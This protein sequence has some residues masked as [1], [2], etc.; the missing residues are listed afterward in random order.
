MRGRKPKSYQEYVELGNSRG[1]T[2]LDKSTPRSINSTAYWECV[3]CGRVMHKSYWKVMV[4][5]P[6]RC[7]ESGL[8]E[9]CELLAKELGIEWAGMLIPMNQKVK[10]SW[11]LSNGNTFDASFNDIAH[12]RH[13][14]IMKMID[15]SKK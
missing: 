10:T 13:K 2:F 11:K 7:R 4:Y 12:Y 8:Q 3:H 1:L 9:K 14:Y 6:C 5:N 15:L